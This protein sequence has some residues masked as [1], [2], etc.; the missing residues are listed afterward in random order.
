MSIST[1]RARRS[2]RGFTLT[3]IAIVLGV[4]GLILGSIWVA[5][6][7]VYNNQ[8]TAKTNTQVLSI[9]QAVRSLYASVASTGDADGTDETTNLCKANVFP[10]DMV[11]GGAP[12]C[13]SVKNVWNGAVTVKSTSKNVAGTGDAFSVAYAGLPTAVCAAL[14]T[15]LGGTSGVWY[16]G[17]P[18][19]AIAAGNVNSAAVTI[20]GAM[21]ATQCTASATANTVSIVFTLKG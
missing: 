3:E 7:S 19:Y 5:A 16:V 20:G 6:S 1:L 13:T 11:T 12:T 10:N 21:A 8:K 4:I 17:V 14:E 2:Q 9:A 15:A 18:A